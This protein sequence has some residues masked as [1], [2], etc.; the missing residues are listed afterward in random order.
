LTAGEA[1]FLACKAALRAR[2]LATNSWYGEGM[3]VFYSRYS[4]HEAELV[5]FLL[6]GSYGYL[7]YAIERS[8]NS[9][10]ILGA[11]LAGMFVTKETWLLHVGVFLISL[12]CLKYWSKIQKESNFEFE[13]EVQTLFKKKE[14]KLFKPIFIIC[15]ISV[16]LLY[17][18]FLY[19][20][21]GILDFF[22]AFVPWMK[23]GTAGNGHDKPYIYWLELIARY[24][25]LL[26]V[27]MALALLLSYKSSKIFR[28]L[29]LNAV[30]TYLAYTIVHYKTPWCAI[31]FLW[32]WFLSDQVSMKI[33]C[34]L[35][36]TK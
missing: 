10:Y 1:L 5:F 28:F 8:K 26:G 9:G 22:F 16:I 34:S 14:I 12:L 27:G 35:T 23:T 31:S 6:L 19:Y 29:G 33:S 18:G 24:E 2:A 21:K 30:G 3:L 25:L 20:P 36:K 11:S 17:G 4:I 15:S 13:S 7:S 32:L